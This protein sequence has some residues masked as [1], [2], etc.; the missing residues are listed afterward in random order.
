MMGISTSG[1]YPDSRIRFF[2]RSR[3]F[4]GSPMSRTKILN[5]AKNLIRLSGYEPDVD[6][7]IVFT[8][9]RPGEK[10]Y[11]ELLMN[12]E[13]MQDTPNKLIHIGKHIEFDMERF[14]GQ[15]EE[16]YVTANED[17]DGIREDVM[18]IVTTYHPAGIKD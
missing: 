11:E 1:S 3:I 17:G 4:M 9:L 13:G 8:G 14:E 6:I 5:L 15:L 10:L 7:P 12:E 2:A 16:L 18:R